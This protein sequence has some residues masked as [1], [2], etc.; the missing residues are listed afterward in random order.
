MARGAGHGLCGV[1]VS[2]KPYTLSKDRGRTFIIDRED[3]DE[4][5]ISNLAGQLMGEFVRTEVAPEIDAYAISAIAKIAVLS[6]NYGVNFIISVSMD[7]EKLPE[8]CKQY[9]AVAL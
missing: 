7:S 1:T 5:G 9:V 8:S 4:I 3:M 2:Q 6:E